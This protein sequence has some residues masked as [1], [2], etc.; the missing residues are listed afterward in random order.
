MNFLFG[1]KYPIYNSQGRLAHRWGDFMER[2]KA[3]Y[4]KNADLD[5]RN[6][7]GLNFSESGEPPA[8]EKRLSENAV[9][10]PAPESAPK[11]A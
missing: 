9:A 6:H 4:Q 8:A 3:R 2:W 5:W 11:K 1:K 7:S 10:K